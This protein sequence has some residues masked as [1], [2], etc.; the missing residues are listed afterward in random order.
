MVAL[1]RD[2]GADQV[3]ARR[4]T[5]RVAPTAGNPVAD[6]FRYPLPA[7]GERARGRGLSAAASLALLGFLLATAAQAQAIRATVDR[8]EATLEDQIVLSVTLEGQ[9]AHPPELPAL[10]DFEVR[11]VGTSTQFQIVAGQTAASVTFTYVLLPRRTGELLIGPIAVEVGGVRR[12]SQPIRVRIVEAE[13]QSFGVPQA[14]APVPGMGAPGRGAPGRAAADATAAERRDLFI[15]AAV[16]NPRPYLG[17]QVVYTWRLYTRV[18]VGEARVGAFEIPGFAVEDLGSAREYQDSFQGQLYRVTE[19][20]KAL[21]PQQE[22]KIAATGPRLEATVLVQRRARTGSLFD[23]IWGRVEQQPRRLGTPPVELEVRPL[24]PA[25]PGFSGLVGR[26]AVDASLSKSSLAAGE[27]T[28]LKV[29]VSGAGNATMIGEPKMPD[30]SAF[31]VYDDKPTASLERTGDQIRGRKTFVKALVPLAAGTLELPALS[32]VYF[33]PAA[34][35][36]RTASSAPLSLAV[37]PGAGHEELRLTEAMAATTGKVAVQVLADDLLPIYRGTDAV[38][39]GAPAQALLAAGLAAPALAFLGLFFWRQRQRR[40]ALDGGL[41]RRQRALRTALAQAGQAQQ[42]AA[43]SR[44]P[45]AVA[46]A[47]LCLRQYVGDKL[48][49]EGTALTP[50]EAGAHLVARGVR[51]ELVA[52]VHGLLG[53]LEGA[54]YCGREAGAELAQLLA[55]LEDTV[56][57]LD[58]DLQAGSGRRAGLGQAGLVSGAGV[59]TL[60]LALVVAGTAAAAAPL[61][62]AV[63]FAAANAAYDAG[64]YSRA[65]ADY[66]ALVARGFDHGHLFYNLGNAYLRNGELGRAIAAY[67][68]AEA[69]QPRSSDLAANLAH[70]RRSAKDALAPPAAPALAAALVPWHYRASRA[71]LWRFLLAVNLLFWSCL[72]L[73]LVLRRGEWLR[74]SAFALALAAAGAAGS[75][76]ARALAPERVAVVVPQE[77]EARAAADPEALVRFKLHAGSE[78][79]VRGHEDGWICVA[80]PSG[81][82][83]WLESTAAVVVER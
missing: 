6:A 1:S 80:L 8:S 82:K 17:E 55:E 21:F 45:E 34:G 32:L 83:G 46:L 60:L 28:T 61:E 15:T 36:Y 39:A 3:P 49:L 68:E 19:V 66:E 65:A 14:G 7:C 20:R 4:A 25:P 63:A 52:R 10:P 35:D 22:G 53:R 51:P 11:P 13:R 44:T 29:T 57:Q 16:S 33:D 38:R 40:F 48:G 67:R 58:R 73:R 2:E 78:V 41:R 71:E 70:A 75:L 54:R 72:A 5:T 43:A 50:D 27:S 79:E 23:E 26:F 18:R 30:L 74:W 42:T 62:P 47:S 59:T 31:K 64:D 24:P 69:R 9:A 81:E 12:E 77:V 37:A 76:A 56:R